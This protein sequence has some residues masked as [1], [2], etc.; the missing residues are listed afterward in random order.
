MHIS[1]NFISRT[2]EGILASSILAFAVRYALSQPFGC[3]FFIALL[4]AI[5]GMASYELGKLIEKKQI[6]IFT[7]LLIIGGSL[8]LLFRAFELL[9]HHG[10]AFVSTTWITCVIGAL[11][12]H[13]L[14]KK[15]DVLAPTACTIF[16]FVYLY[17][18][19]WIILEMTYKEPAN[20]W[21]L[22]WT[23]LIVK[24]S[25][26]AAYFGGKLLGKRPLTKIS[27]KKTQEGF[28]IGCIA[29][30]LISILMGLNSHAPSISLVGFFILGILLAILTAIGDL[31]ESRFKREAGIKDSNTKLQGLGGFLDMVDSLVFTVPFAYLCYLYFGKV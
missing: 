2:I 28:F 6:S 3:W 22:I 15:S 10:N 5:V 14:Y 8:F 29:G 24:G 21:W 16:G 25:D 7:P 4:T 13:I 9:H 18:P 20:R 12:F 19:T 1:K 27:P 31:I 17:L 23:L 30:A 11:S 26:I